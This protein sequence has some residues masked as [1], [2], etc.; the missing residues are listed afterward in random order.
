MD[1]A[2]L[3]HVGLAVRDVERSV[4]WYGEVLGLQR[5]YQDAWGDYPAVMEANGTGVALFPARGKPIEPSTFDSLA[6]VGF[7]V[8]RESYEQARSELT[9]AGVEFRESDHKVA[10]SIYLL[11]PDSHLIE[12]TTYGPTE[13]MT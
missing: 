4:R 2:G 1:I 10:W 11:D 8:S 6:H 3:D 13:A 12:I 9:A 7:R 5:A